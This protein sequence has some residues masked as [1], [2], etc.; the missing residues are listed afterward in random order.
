MNETVELTGL[1]AGP[2]CD[3]LI[4]AIV[5]NLLDPLV[6]RALRDLVLAKVES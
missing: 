2:A 6:S 5:T 4:D 3:R 1:R